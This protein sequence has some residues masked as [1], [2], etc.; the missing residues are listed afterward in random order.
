MGGD[1]AKVNGVAVVLD[2]ADRFRGGEELKAVMEITGGE[3]ATAVFDATGS[4]RALESGVDY[5]SHGGR[6]VL[7]G[8]SK[9][10]LTF[11]HPK[12]HAKETTL[13]CSRNATLEDFEKVISILEKG[14]FPIDSFITHNVDYSD[15]ITNFD[16]WLDPKTGVIKAT[17]NF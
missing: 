11:T 7:V 10:D 13:M 14:E 17:V 12:I 8:L 15:M 2:A 4:Q 5:M 16:S 3:L 6:Y 9:G 1:V